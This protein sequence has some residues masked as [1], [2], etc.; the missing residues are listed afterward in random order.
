MA[1]SAVSAVRRLDW[2]SVSGGGE[3]F[4][5]EGFR[6][7]W[8]GRVLTHTAT[9]AV[10]FALL[11]A[12]VGSGQ[13]G[14]S[15][16]SAL[17]VTAY[18]LPTATLGTISGVFVDRLPKNV[19]LAAVNVARA[20]LMLLLLMGDTSLWTVYGVALLLAVTSQFGTPAEAASLPRVVRS[21]QLTA[22]TSANQFAGLVAQVLGLVVLAPLFLN[23]TGPLPLYVI[24]ALLF[25]AGVAAFITMP[26]GEEQDLDI[27]RTIDSVREV[28]RQFAQAWDELNRDA[29]AYMSVIIAVLAS[30]ASLVAV[31]LMPQFVQDV[32]DIPVQNAI[33]VFLPSAIGIVLGLRLVSVLE[34]RTPKMWLTSAGFLLFMASLA[35]LALTVPLATILAGIVPVSNLAARVC[36]V[37]VFS[38]VATFSFSVLGVSSRSLVHERMPVGL[39]GRIFAA[40]HV[41]ANLASIGPILF[42]GLLAEV[43]SVEPVMLLMVAVIL[44]VAGWTAASTAARPQPLEPV[45]EE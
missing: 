31:T 20:G 40:Q 13:D 39:Q 15:L 42:V 16:K 37:V 12:V 10:L 1:G 2:R 30:T 24:S 26:L 36:V 9:N 33:Y 38:A 14:S 35:C 27:D 19:V 8:L 41:L 21:D 4:Q 17:F 6:K 7:L 34:R 23:T 43:F 3:L 22:A 44:A 28:R 29:S 11:V 25:C 18:I 5:D 32:L 45:D